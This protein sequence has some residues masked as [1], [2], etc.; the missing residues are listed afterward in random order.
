MAFSGNWE[1]VT[2]L[3]GQDPGPG[4]V[5]HANTALGALNFSNFDDDLGN[6]TANL[7]SVTE[8]D[9]I[10]TPDG[11]WTATGDAIDLG[12]HTLIPITPETQYG[13]DGV[14]L[15][16]F[17]ASTDVTLT[18]AEVAAY[19]L[20][21]VTQDD[22]DVA[23]YVITSETGFTPTQHRDLRAIPETN[24]KRAWAIVSARVRDETVADEDTGVTA[25][26]QDD[27]SYSKDAETARKFVVYP[28]KLQGL[29]MVLLDLS[30]ST[31]FYAINRL[32][33]SHADTR[34]PVRDDFG[35]IHP[36]TRV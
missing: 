30:P 16:T 17:T 20:G 9:I 34:P 4:D 36:R 24:V 26:T 21:T 10:S 29:P 25:E 11:Q 32:P 7:Q 1:Y 31:T 5:V 35:V 12:V 2:P 23:E 27:Y 18:P 28:N 6:Q 8:G 13:V 22:I 14:K 3:T 15:F 19:G 33:S